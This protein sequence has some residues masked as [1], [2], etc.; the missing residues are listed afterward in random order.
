LICTVLQADT[1]FRQCCAVIV[2]IA[3]IAI[4]AAMLLPALSAARERARSANC[5]SKLKQIGLAL[6][7]YAGDNVSN[8][9]IYT[10]EYLNGSSFDY[11]A[12]PY[13]LMKSG[14]LGMNL[15]LAAADYSSTSISLD[16]IDRS[17]GDAYQCPSDASYPR[18]YNNVY[19]GSYWFVFY[20]KAS[21]VIQA[22]SDPDTYARGMVTDEPGNAI[23][24]DMWPFAASYITGGTAGAYNNHPSNANVLAIGGHVHTVTTKAVGA[25][26]GSGWTTA[27]FDVF[28]GR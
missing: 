1:I 16:K 2:V 19:S 9:P 13:I 7:M 10:G 28:D 5:T 8:L 26:A 3:I 23:V 12:A 11:R 25:I 17:F 27:R 14:Y 4:L 18:K 20:R 6:H 24:M 22:F 15:N 21:S